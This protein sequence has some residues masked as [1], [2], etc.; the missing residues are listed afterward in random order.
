MF[1][2]NIFVHQLFFDHL[3][4]WWGQKWSTAALEGDAISVPVLETDLQAVLRGASHHKLLPSLLLLLAP[5]A[6]HYKSGHDRVL[7]FLSVGA[8]KSDPAGISP[9]FMW[10]QQLDMLI[11]LTTPDPL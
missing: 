5:A 11:A 7:Y 6:D 9:V 8:C 10:P 4:K 2:C 1:I 3:I